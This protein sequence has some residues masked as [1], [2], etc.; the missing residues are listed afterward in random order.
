[1]PESVG[2]ASKPRIMPLPDRKPKRWL[3]FFTTFKPYWAS[4]TIS[5]F[6]D[7]PDFQEGTQC[8]RECES[9]IPVRLKMIYHREHRGHRENNA[10][11]FNALK[12][13]RSLCPLWLVINWAKK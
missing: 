1:M 10:N 6:S 12:T 5:K 8:V 13:L 4:R 11:Q 2:S 3:I 7:K 9:I